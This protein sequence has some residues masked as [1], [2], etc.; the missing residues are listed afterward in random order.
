M[1]RP[2]SS[3][4]AWLAAFAL[5]TVAS[6]V[7]APWPEEQA[8]QQFG[9]AG[10]VAFFVVAWRRWNASR[11]ALALFLAFLVLH[12]VGARWVY[13]F[14]PY[15]DWI[16]SVLGLRPGER[17]HWSRNH[18]DRF[19]HLL[20]G[21]LAMPL[22]AEVLAR[23]AVPRRGAAIGLAVTVVIATSALYEIG[24]WIVAFVAAPERAE[25]YLGQQGD[26]WDAQWDMALATAG[27][28]ATASVLALRRPRG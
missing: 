16:E 27:A 5:L 8:L 7:R 24:E 25:R 15:D 19:V 22:F 21:M 12:V 26:M 28:C 17:F 14:V 9:T 6:L 13:S 1:Q 2:W 3:P 10:G 20:Y 11:G 18:Y 4:A 23:T